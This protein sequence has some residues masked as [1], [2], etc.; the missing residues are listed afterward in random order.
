QLGA[1]IGAEL[2][3]P[4]EAVGE[5]QTNAAHRATVERGAVE[6]AALERQA[7]PAEVALGLAVLAAALVRASGLAVVREPGLAP[8]RPVGRK[9]PAGPASD[10][11]RLPVGL[12]QQL[13]GVVPLE[14]RELALDGVEPQRNQPIEQRR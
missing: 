12:A 6:R 1:T 9:P 11:D 13:A 10:D 8:G 14:P 2:A 7:K 5:R 4:A 3:V